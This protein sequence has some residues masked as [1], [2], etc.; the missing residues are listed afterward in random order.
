MGILKN[1]GYQSK[2]GLARAKELQ[3]LP[4]DFLD[5]APFTV[6]GKFEVIGN[7]VPLPLGRAVAR[8]VRQAMGYQLEATA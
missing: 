8:A 4:A 1:F 5:D 2:D 3:G 7:G 6:S